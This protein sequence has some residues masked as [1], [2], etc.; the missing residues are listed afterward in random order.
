MK[1]C[2][3]TCHFW[4]PS[5]PKYGYT[6]PIAVLSLNI[7]AS[8]PTY[9]R[10][11]R[12][13]NS[14]MTAF[15][16]S[17]KSRKLLLSASSQQFMFFTWKSARLPLSRS[18]S[19]LSINPFIRFSRSLSKSSSGLL[20]A[21]VSGWKTSSRLSCDHTKQRY[22]SAS[23]LSSSSMACC[24]IFWSSLKGTDGFG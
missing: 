2:C 7:E 22:V 13:S 10:L 16:I 9:T 19:R 23:R 11:P 17:F 5:S 14:G 1:L 18:L 6:K 8:R 12:L 15:S 24:K 4:L 3:S 21:H 20:F